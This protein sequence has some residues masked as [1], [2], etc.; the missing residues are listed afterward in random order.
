MVTVDGVSTFGGVVSSGSLLLLE[1][2]MKRMKSKKSEKL[3]LDV[4]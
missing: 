2:P 1:Q 4:I 3:I